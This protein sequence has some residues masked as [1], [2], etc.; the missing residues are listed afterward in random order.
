MIDRNMRQLLKFLQ[1]SSIFA[2]LVLPILLVIVGGEEP[3]SF[4]QYYFTPAGWIFVSTLV[5]ISIGLISTQNY[6]SALRG[7]CLQVVAFFDCHNYGELHNIAAVLF[8]VLSFF[9]IIDDKRHR[10]IGYLM[11][12]FAPIC[13]MSLYYGELV[14]ILLISLFHFLYFN[15]IHRIFFF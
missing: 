1:Y 3:R 12:F 14:Q 10:F 6:L 7:V 15:R 13:T 4:S 11:L 8:F 2:S 9:Q 5:W